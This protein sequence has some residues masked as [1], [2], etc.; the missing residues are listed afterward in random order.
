MTRLDSPSRRY[1][2]VAGNS[3][4]NYYSSRDAAAKYMK[5]LAKHSP[6][7]Y[8]EAGIQVRDADDPYVYHDLSPLCY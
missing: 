4:L 6:D 5:E 8:A 1:R 7:T 3:A 2:V